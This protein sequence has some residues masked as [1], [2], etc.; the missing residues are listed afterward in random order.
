MKTNLNSR[1]LCLKKALLTTAI[2]F[3]AITLSQAYSFEKKNLEDLDLKIE[4]CGLK[5]LPSIILVDK[6]LRIVAE[7]YGDSNDVKKQFGETFQN[8]QQLSTYNNQGIYLALSH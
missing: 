6:N 5:E 2:I 8:A 1:S 7:F 3:G 4:I